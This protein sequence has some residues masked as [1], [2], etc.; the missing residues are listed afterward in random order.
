MNN[1]LK[2]KYGS[3]S[4]LDTFSKKYKANVDL[5]NELSDELSDDTI[6]NLLAIASYHII[7]DFRNTQKIKNILNFILEIPKNKHNLV[8]CINISHFI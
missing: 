5:S 7:N 6:M 8:D 2:R 3:L 1:N 4:L